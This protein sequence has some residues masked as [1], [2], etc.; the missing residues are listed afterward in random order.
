[1]G[2]IKATWKASQGRGERNL[3]P[4]ELIHFDICEMN[5]EKRWK[6]IFMTSID[7]TTRFAMFTWSNLRMKHYTTLNSISLKLRL[8]R[9]ED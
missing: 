3:A 1:M 8:T 2:A 6:E 5:W 7:D 9:G 4:L